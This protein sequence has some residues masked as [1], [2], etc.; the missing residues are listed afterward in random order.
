MV[1]DINLKSGWNFR[2]LKNIL[3]TFFLLY[4]YYNDVRGTAAI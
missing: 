4:K 1:I 2:H 3:S